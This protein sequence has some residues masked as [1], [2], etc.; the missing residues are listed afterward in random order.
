[1]IFRLLLS[2]LLLQ[3]CGHKNHPP[4]Q[5]PKEPTISKTKILKP[6]QVTSQKPKSQKPSFESKI[7]PLPSKEKPP[8][9][10]KEEKAIPPQDHLLEADRLYK[11][12]KYEEAESSYQK[13]IE[14]SNELTAE[15][16]FKLG[17]LYY[18][19]ADWNRAIIY[20]TESYDLSK[21]FAQQAK[22]FEGS[23]YYAKRY[24]EPAMEAFKTAIQLNTTSALTAASKNFLNRLENIEEKKWSYVASFGYAHDTNLT[25]VATTGLLNDPEVSNATSSSNNFLF[26]PTYKKSFGLENFFSASYLLYVSWQWNRNHR[27]YNVYRQGLSSS[28]QMPWHLGGEVTTTLKGL[29]DFTM[30]GINQGQHEQTDEDTRTLSVHED[31]FLIHEVSPFNNFKVGLPLH[32]GNY[33]F[34]S[35]HD[36]EDRDSLVYEAGIDGTYFLGSKQK[37]AS[38]GYLFL[39]DHTAGITYDAYHHKFTYGFFH[40]FFAKTFFKF[41]GS[42][43]RKLFSNNADNRN[44]LEYTFQNSL[45]GTLGTFAATTS[46]T[47]VKNSSSVGRY[48]YDR[49]LVAFNLTKTF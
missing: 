6:E 27:G 18:D 25:L 44:D 40:P 34:K 49:L 19:Q 2:L 36:A 31:L 35:G 47:Y 16:S 43:I 3:A 21:K 30:A 28:I 37:W 48:D 42:T 20:F 4:K 45:L 13:A 5:A 26:E 22:Y 9:P 11:E 46:L 41:Y 1:M 8:L 15:A 10:L 23:A 33:D 17:L 24:R 38:L 29:A 7:S 39:K 32:F 14:A 12:K